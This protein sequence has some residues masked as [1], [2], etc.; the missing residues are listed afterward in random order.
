MPTAPE[1]APTPVPRVCH[2]S[3]R[4]PEGLTRFKVYCEN[5]HPARPRYILATSEAQ[6]RTF[7]LDASGLAGIYAK[8]KDRKARDVEEPTLVVVKM[9]D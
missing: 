5:Y 4:A 8:L 7:Y 9:P 3:E 6:A 1:A 2:Q